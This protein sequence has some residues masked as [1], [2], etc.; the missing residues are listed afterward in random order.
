LVATIAFTTACSGHGDGSSVSIR[1]GA[2]EYCQQLA[3]LPDGLIDAVS[4]TAS[5]NSSESDKSIINQAATQLRGA[6][7]GLSVSADMKSKLTDAATSLDKLAQ[8]QQLG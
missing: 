3:K 4:N 8:D 7:G 2:P 6:A 1:D 5:G